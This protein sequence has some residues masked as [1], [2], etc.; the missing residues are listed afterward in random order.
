VLK[1]PW[2]EADHSS[3]S[4]AE[5]YTWCY[6]STLPVRLLSWCLVKYMDYFTT[7]RSALGLTKSQSVSR[8][9]S[10]GFIQLGREA[11]NSSPSSAEVNNAWNYIST[12]PIGLHCVVLS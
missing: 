10:L 12:P 4:T 5:I 8:A 2:R 3:P 9:L 11:N 7:S 1:R 6:T